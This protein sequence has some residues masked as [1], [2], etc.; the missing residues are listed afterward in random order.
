[1]R[2]GFPLAFM[3]TSVAALVAVGTLRPVDAQDA[4]AAQAEATDIFSKADDQLAAAMAFAAQADCASPQAKHAMAVYIDNAVGDLNKLAQQNPSPPQRPRLITDTPDVPHNVAFMTQSL[5]ASL[6]RYLA[7]PTCL[8]PR[9]P[10]VT[11]GPSSGPPPGTG[12]SGGGLPGGGSEGPLPPSGGD[13]PGPQTPPPSQTPEPDCPGANA[14]EIRRL[15]SAI[16]NVQ[17]QIA[18]DQDKLQTDLQIQAR[19]ESAIPNLEASIKTMQ[20]PGAPQSSA[21]DIQFWQ[22]ALDSDRQQLLD[23]QRDIEGDKN[24]LNA[25]KSRLENLKRDLEELK[26]KAC[27]DQSHSS[28]LQDILGHVSIG[29]GI[30]VGGG[31]DDRGDKGNDRG[32]DSG[33]RTPHD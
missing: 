8:P 16:D 24:D 21:E 23:V 29:V 12:V 13:G 11:S 10:D 3:L 15:E 17:S 5:T 30:G 28:V 20:N 2:R 1:M 32:G 4:R 7:L 19:L 9:G 27:G 6:D 14:E 18:Q 31:H 26:K 33:P 25:D 22:D